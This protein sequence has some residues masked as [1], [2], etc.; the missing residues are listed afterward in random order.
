MNVN[1]ELLKEIKNYCELNDIE[2]VDG[3]I[4]KM[5]KKGFTIEKY[6]LTPTS[7]V[8]KK[9]VKVVEVK[10]ETP[11]EN[12]TINDVVLDKTEDT[13]QDDIYGNE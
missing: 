6:G 4:T 2:D 7:P 11:E 9:E 10:N 13:I 3:L 12:N 8:I 1:P 5:L